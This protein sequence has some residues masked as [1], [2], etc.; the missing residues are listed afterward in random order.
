[1][2]IPSPI[3][4]AVMAHARF[5][6]PEECCGLLA[7]DGDGSIRFA[8]PLTNSYHSPVRF[9]IEPAEMFGAL[10]HAESNGWEL[11]GS[12]H[13][14]PAGPAY[15]SPTD[16]AEAAEPGWLYLVASLRPSELRG[17]RL[18][19]AAPVEVALEVGQPFFAP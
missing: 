5:C 13:S 10:R 17:F 2:Q 16:Q 1:V 11:A 8:Y 6:A 14:H 19:G 15:P 9:N 4:E 7:A 18:S 12:F 3:W